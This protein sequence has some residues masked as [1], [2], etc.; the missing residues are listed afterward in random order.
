MPPNRGT[1]RAP[2]HLSD[3]SRALWRRIDADYELEDHHRRLLTLAC[4]ALDRCDQ[5]RT[6]LTEHGLVCMDGQG[7]PKPRPEV[8][9]E[10][11]ARIAVARLFRELNL[12][13]APEEARPPRR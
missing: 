9:I 3:Q 1:R 11:D 5:A 2:G 8:G 7:N 10:R 4:E 6:A 12:E 13:D